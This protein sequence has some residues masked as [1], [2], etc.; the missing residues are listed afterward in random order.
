MLFQEIA[1]LAEQRKE[2][3]SDYEFYET[4]VNVSYSLVQF[5]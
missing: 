2:K 4:P 5:F 3:K 1:I